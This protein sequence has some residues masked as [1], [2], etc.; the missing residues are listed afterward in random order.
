MLFHKEDKAMLEHKIRLRTRKTIYLI[1]HFL[2]AYFT[3]YRLV[4]HI[5]SYQILFIFH[6]KMMTWSHRNVVL[7]SY[8]CF[9]H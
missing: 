8:N 1:C 4:Q 2:H 3:F 5:L 7:N 9:Y 6:L